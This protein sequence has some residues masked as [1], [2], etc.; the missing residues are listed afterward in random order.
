MPW[1]FFLRSMPIFLLQ[2]KLKWPTSHQ[3]QSSR[4]RH[5]FFLWIFIIIFDAFLLITFSKESPVWRPSDKEALELPSQKLPVSHF[6]CIWK[7]CNSHFQMSINYCIFFIFVVYSYF[8]QFYNYFNY[9]KFNSKLKSLLHRS[10]LIRE[11]YY[12]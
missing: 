8:F 11:A 1:H 6:F 5:V 4:Q 12:N 3:C 2:A 7:F 10:K 9:I